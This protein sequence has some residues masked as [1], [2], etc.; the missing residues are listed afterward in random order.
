MVNI[1][2]DDTKKLPGRTPD[3]NIVRTPMDQ[4]EIAGR[5]DHLPNQ[6]KSEDMTISHVPNRG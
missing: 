1:F 4:N 2:K 3:I 5:K 6:H